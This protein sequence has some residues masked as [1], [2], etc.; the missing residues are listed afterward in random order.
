MHVG[1]ARAEKIAKNSRE[2]SIEVS[3]ACAERQTFSIANFPGDVVKVEDPLHHGLDVSC[4]G[5]S[6]LIRINDLFRNGILC[7]GMS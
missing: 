2:G 6:I 7:N 1:G 4:L 5:H 3:V